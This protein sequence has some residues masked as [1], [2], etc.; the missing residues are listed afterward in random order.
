MDI[1]VDQK[2]VV[3]FDLDDTL[4]NE[5]DYLRSAYISIAK[6]L[7][8]EH[9]R[10]LFAKMFSLFRSKEDVFEFVSLKYKIDKPELIETYRAHIPVLS[11]FDGVFE[12]MRTIKKRGGKIGI[13]TDGRKSTQTVKIKAL[14]IHPL[15]DKVVISEEIGSEKPDA[16]NYLIIEKAFPDCHYLYV[17]DNLRKDFITPNKLGW[18]TIG[19]IDNGLNMHY[20]GHQYFDP[21]QSP[22]SFVISFGE[23]NI[24]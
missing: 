19:L 10:P 18:Q 7:A 9:W 14:G 23:L 22:K 21:V 24:V 2:T 6:N 15:L 5:M 12:T 3:V 20:D 11:T 13:I 8:P 17:A 1:K 16:N 4:Y